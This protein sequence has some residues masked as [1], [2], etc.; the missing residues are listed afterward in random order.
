[1]DFVWGW[2]RV[3]GEHTRPHYANS[4]GDK[5]P[6]RVQ[7]PDGIPEGFIPGRHLPAA[8]A[9]S[10]EWAE[11]CAFSKWG[12]C[13]AGYYFAEG[14]CTKCPNVGDLTPAGSDRCVCADGTAQLDDLVAA[15][16][17][18]SISEQ[19]SHAA[20][21]CYACSAQVYML[22]KKEV[23]PERVVCLTN[24]TVTR[25][26]ANEI[27][28]Q[29]ACVPC[30]KG[31]A[32]MASKEAC[33]KC[34][35]GMYF[36]ATATMQTCV[37]CDPRLHF[38][39]E[40]GM[41]EPRPRTMQC[42]A[43][44]MLRI[45]E[46]PIQDNAC[47]PC[48]TS[49]GA[50]NYLV[51]AGGH[52]QSNGC[53]LTVAEGSGVEF[54]A[55]Y[56][57]TGGDRLPAF[58]TAGY[59]LRFSAAAAVEKKVVVERC[60]EAW[61]PPY[62]VWVASGTEY[63]QGCVFACQYGW[64]VSLGQELQRQIEQTISEARPDLALFWHTVLVN[65]SP[66]NAAKQ[67]GYALEKGLWPQSMAKKQWAQSLVKEVQA[68]DDQS[69][70]YSRQNTFLHLEAENNAVLPWPD[71]LCLAPD[72]VGKTPC[73]MGYAPSDREGTLP[74]PCALLARTHGLVKVPQ[75]AQDQSKSF[76]A[77]VDQE[78]AIQC[79]VTEDTLW[80]HRW[81]SY[82]QCEAC[83]DR[84]RSTS[85]TL[86]L[87]AAQKAW[88]EFETPFP[89]R[90]AFHQHDTCEGITCAL[91][92][93][94]WGVAC[95]PC[96]QATDANWTEVCGSEV[97]D[98]ARCNGS[99]PL[100][101][102]DVCVPCLGEEQ[103]K[104]SI[105][106][107]TQ[108]QLLSLWQHDRVGWPN[109]IPCKY[110]CT[111]GYTSQSDASAYASTPCVPCVDVVQAFADKGVC[112]AGSESVYSVSEQQALCVKSEG[113]RR[114]VPS[115]KP[116]AARMAGLLLKG[117]PQGMVPSYDA[118]VA[119]CDPGLYFTLHVNGSKVSTPVPQIQI[120]RC[121]P[122]GEEHLA[123]CSNLTTCVDDYYWCASQFCVFGFCLTQ[124]KNVTGTGH[125]ASPAPRVCVTRCLAS[126]DRA[127]CKARI[128]TANAWRA[129][130][131][132]CCTMMW[133]RGPLLRAPGFSTG[134]SWG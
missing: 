54:F 92:T 113:Y 109:N 3:A 41:S 107:G 8:S 105:I 63:P 64:N 72:E 94:A 12:M 82:A 27:V 36:D 134:A 125:S 114:F 55:C 48:A 123:N 85:L 108:K 57:T 112:G 87:P 47:E 98:R 116:C 25:C 10:A 35:K 89:E 96:E 32:A 129:M 124:S 100:K 26:G 101:R 93:V 37:A 119:L 2:Q 49:C 53:S 20:Q 121:V 31:E 104:G 71:G 11:D 90:Y 126:I 52:N 38:C 120:L 61:L 30:G 16:P 62:A 111:Y 65:L 77:V 106:T 40:E 46:N 15:I 50:G 7:C 84:L 133:R 44:Q 21:Y 78:H 19:A 66:G 127:A 5:P 130:R 4:G 67:L 117:M 33:V 17:S 23:G 73:P 58:T 110:S 28:V 103:A 99:F 79:H 74:L 86:K 81:S 102:E 97:F 70:R 128:S 24:R 69:L 34:P 91:S 45:G 132:G 18:A 22:Q 51:Y 68:L 6:E 88:L 43:G 13:M 131:G 75:L 122:C 118:C 1:M 76:V 80:T 14:K 39:P 95:V 59:R 29:N 42:P 115:C 9:R 60:E 83:L 56:P